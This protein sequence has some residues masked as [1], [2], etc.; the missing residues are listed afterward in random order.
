MMHNNIPLLC[1]DTICSTRYIAACAPHIQ[2]WLHPPP[3]RGSYDYMRL[4]RNN[5]MPLSTWTYS[6]LLNDGWDAKVYP[7]ASVCMEYELVMHPTIYTTHMQVGS[8]IIS[9]RGPDAAEAR[10][11]A[12]S[13]VAACAK[14]IMY[15]QSEVY[16]IYNQLFL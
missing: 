11:Q 10:L 3:L 16:I 7:Q 6:Q 8:L 4:T 2:E 13:V 14:G 9:H 5:H 15:F 1:L 12:M